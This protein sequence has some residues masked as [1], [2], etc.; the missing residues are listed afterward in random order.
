MRASITFL[1][2]RRSLSKIESN[3]NGVIIAQCGATGLFYGGYVERSLKSAG[4]AADTFHRAVVS[5]RRSSAIKINVGA[6]WERRGKRGINETRGIFLSIFRM[7][8]TLLIWL[9]R[10]SGAQIHKGKK[11]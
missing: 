8:R 11:D 2:E 3:H 4:K 1:N 5:S 9:F 7:F 6:L 10:K